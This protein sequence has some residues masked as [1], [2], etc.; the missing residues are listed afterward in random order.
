MARRKDWAYAITFDEDWSELHRFE[1]TISARATEFQVTWRRVGHLGI[2]RQIGDR[3]TNGFNH[4]SG[5]QMRD[6][7]GC[8]WGSGESFL[9]TYGGEGRHR[10]NRTR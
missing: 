9:V 6:M 5:P 1:V 3:H 7:L 4:L 2:E 10:A 8:G